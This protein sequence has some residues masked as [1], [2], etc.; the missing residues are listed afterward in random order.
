MADSDQGE[1]SEQATDTRREEFRNRGQVAHSK[2]FASALFFLSAAGSLYMV[3]R[4]S[5]MHIHDVFNAVFGLDMVQTIRQGD[6]FEIVKI[7]SFK[8]GIVLL[9]IL[10]MAVLLGALSSIC[11][12]VF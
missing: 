11:K 6:P 2:E 12:L 4:F 9:P 5:F 7:A 10:A 8:V 1:K 3:S